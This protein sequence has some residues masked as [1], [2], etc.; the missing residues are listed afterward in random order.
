MVSFDLCYTSRSEEDKDKL[1]CLILHD[2]QSKIV[3]A[4]PVKH[5]G[6][7]EWNRFLVS[8][9]CRFLNYLGHHEVTLHSEPTLKSD[10]EPSLVNLQ[11]AAQTA[12]SQM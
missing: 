11:R 2:R 4:I 8:K 1:M 7:P 6:G 12:R 3:E 10:P 5:K 9:I